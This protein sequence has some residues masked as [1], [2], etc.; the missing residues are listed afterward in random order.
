MARMIWEVETKKGQVEMSPYEVLNLLMG[1]VVDKERP[2]MEALSQSFAKY[3]QSNEAM[4][5]ITLTQLIS[6]SME[7]GYFYRVFKTQN[8]IKYT[9]VTDETVDSI[10]EST[11]TN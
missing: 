9:E 3:L 5:D 1:K 8:K 4:S 11:P 7:V 6:M 10:S 2:D